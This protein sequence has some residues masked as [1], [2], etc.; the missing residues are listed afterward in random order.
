MKT[1]SSPSKKALKFVFY[2]AAA[3]VGVIL[4]FTTV[5]NKGER[6]RDGGK[7][8]LKKTMI[9]VKANK[10]KLNKRQKKELSL[11][12]K[13]QRI[14]NEMIRSVIPNVTE[15]TIRRDL[16]LLEEKGYIRK[17]GKTKGSYYELC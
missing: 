6:L 3:V 16:S 12:E 13:E 9:M 17:I 5:K 10:D 7:R 11:F 14:T 15:R 1:K 4:A 2:G 8:L